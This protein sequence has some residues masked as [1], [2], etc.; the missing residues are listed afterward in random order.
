MRKLLWIALLVSVLCYGYILGAQPTEPLFTAP[1]DAIGVDLP[2]LNPSIVLRQRLVTIQFHLLANGDATAVHLNP[3][4]DAQLTA[5]QERNERNAAGGYAWYG[6]VE[7]VSPAQVVLVVEGFK[8]AASITQGDRKYTVRHV[9]G[10]LHLVREMEL[11]AVPTPSEAPRT[12]SS[13]LQGAPSSFETKILTLVNQERAAQNLYSLSWDTE[14]HD[15][16]H[17]HSV[18]MA[19]NNYFSHTSQDGR[20]F[21]DRIAA[22]GYEYN[23]AG[24]N[25]A[26]GYSTP[27]A[28]MNGWMNSDGHKANILNSSYCD[29][30]VGYAY[31]SGSTYGHY[32]TQDFGRRTGVFSCSSA[33]NQAPSASFTATPISGSQPLTVHFNASAST[34][35]DGSI[36]SFSWSFGDGQTGTGQKPDHV[37][38]TAGTFTVTLTVT[39]N[40]GASDS[41]VRA[42]LIT[43]SNPSTGQYNLTIQVTGQGTVTMNPTGGSYAAGTAVTLTAT[44]DSGWQLSGWSGDLTGSANPA[45]ITM[46]ANKIVT[47]TFTETS[48]NDPAGGGGSGGGGGGC[49]IATAGCGSG[50]AYQDG[51][52]RRYVDKNVVPVND[53]PYRAIR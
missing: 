45:T 42:N 24:E 51:I 19:T 47:A 49:F 1:V 22:A 25:I 17:S 29:L 6:R 28:A 53:R 23:T 36:A 48:N 50:S 13:A 20:T 32:W 35:P 52:L 30:G 12:L 33:G 14:L 26:A 3:F 7:G 46:D 44:P 21:S 8:L 18:D 4:D 34:D 27:E 31:D 41:L 43:V 37:Y 9:S 11:T 10:D 38:T 16:A 5:V 15:A 2:P 39:D 40:E